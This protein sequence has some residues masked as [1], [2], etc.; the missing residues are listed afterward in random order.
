MYTVQKTTVNLSY[1]YVVLRNGHKIHESKLTP[2]TAI[3]L[4]QTSLNN[5]INQ[6]DRVISNDADG[7]EL[8][9]FGTTAEKFVMNRHGLVAEYQGKQRVI[10]TQRPGDEVYI[11]L[12]GYTFNSF[13]HDLKE[14]RAELWRKNTPTW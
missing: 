10:A 1:V 2:N 7:V 12:P 11:L 6:C 9:I 14:A 4:N 3:S 5:L 8:R 13:K